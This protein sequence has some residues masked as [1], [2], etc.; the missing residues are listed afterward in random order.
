MSSGHICTRDGLC[1]S[2]PGNASAFAAQKRLA[3]LLLIHEFMSLAQE[4][5]VTIG[6]L[7]E[8]FEGRISLTEEQVKITVRSPAD[9]GSEYTFAKVSAEIMIDA[10]GVSGIVDLERD[11]KFEISGLSTAFGPDIGLLKGT[12]YLHGQRLRLAIALKIAG[13]HCLI[14][15]FP[16]KLEGV[17]ELDVDVA[18][19]L[20]SI[21]T[22]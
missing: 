17:G 2:G 7:L 4:E 15:N 8:E 6:S 21:G 13:R 14:A 11:I 22:F 5:R 19:D 10:S 9:A 12:L 20:S 3:R 18:I 16:L 1:V